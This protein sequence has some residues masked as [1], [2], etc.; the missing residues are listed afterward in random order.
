[1]AHFLLCSNRKSMAASHTG[2]FNFH[3]TW[4]TAFGSV[5]NP[6]VNSDSLLTTL[7]IGLAIS[8]FKVNLFHFVLQIKTMYSEI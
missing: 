2:L 8:N 4:Y 6:I 3:R 5:D 1:M 7:E